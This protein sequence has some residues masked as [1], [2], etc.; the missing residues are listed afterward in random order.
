MTDC[1]K[2]SEDE[3]LRIRKQAKQQHQSVSEYLG[4]QRSMP[5]CRSSHFTSSSV[6]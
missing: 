3:A 6:K 4:V 5:R 2:V 1:F